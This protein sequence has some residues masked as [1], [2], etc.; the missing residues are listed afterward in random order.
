MNTHLQILLQA[1]ALI[2]D[3]DNWIQGKEYDLKGFCAFGAV[4]HASEYDDNVCWKVM[5]YLKRELPRR[6]V[7]FRWRSVAQYNDNKT[8]ADVMALFDRAIARLQWSA[9]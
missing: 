4:R 5:A 1:R 6:W 8:H 3:P 7:F 9:A 2:S